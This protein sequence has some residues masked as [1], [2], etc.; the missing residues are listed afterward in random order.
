VVIPRFR[1]FFDTSVYIAALLSPRGASGELIRL[2]E[3]GAVTM[4]VSQRVVVESDQVLSRKFPD[5]IEESRR[6]WKGLSP[7]VTSDPTDRQMAPF[8][9]RLRPG[10]AAILCSAS[11]AQVSAFVTWNTR[12]FMRPGIE[13]LVSFP[14]VVP[15]ECLKR[16]RGWIEPFLD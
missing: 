1:I 12:D 14:I 2:A 8:R 15:P 3:A 13:S 9:A 16:F 11:L 6:L 5:L 10:D 4:V 7:E